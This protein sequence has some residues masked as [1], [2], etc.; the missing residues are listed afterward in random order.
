MPSRTSREAAGDEDGWPLHS[1]KETLAATWTPITAP[2][3]KNIREWA[4]YLITMTM[5]IPHS[6]HPTGTTLGT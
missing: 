1:Q 2:S 4:P 6:F 5:T 3:L